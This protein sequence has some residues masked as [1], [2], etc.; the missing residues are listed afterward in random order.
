MRLGN[1][2]A[3]M[4]FKAKPASWTENEWGVALACFNVGTM[5]LSV[6]ALSLIF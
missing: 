5:L 4:M 6:V 3:E 1:L 2:Y